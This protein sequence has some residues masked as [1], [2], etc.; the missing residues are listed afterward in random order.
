MNWR[1]MGRLVTTVHTAKVPSDE[2]WAEYMAG[3]DAYLPLEAQRILVLSAGGGPTSAQRKLMTDALDG[4]KVPVAI[5][6]SSWTMRG[7]ATAVSWFNPSLQVF[8]PSALDAAF[9]HLELTSWERDESIRVIHELQQALGVRV[10][11]SAS[12]A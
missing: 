10:T 2:D 5:L 8:G 11:A 12:V 3:V 7:A 9:E 1:R 6:T 4:A